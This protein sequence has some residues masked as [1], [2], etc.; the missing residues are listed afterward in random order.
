[1]TPRHGAW[2][3]HQGMV[4]RRV[5]HSITTALSRFPTATIRRFALTIGAVLALAYGVGVEVGRGWGF[6]TLGVGMLLLDYTAEG[7]DERP[8]VL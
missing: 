1:M 3:Y 8:T 4:T 7:D 6:V 2:S 5:T